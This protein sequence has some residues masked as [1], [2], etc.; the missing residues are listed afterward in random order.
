MTSQYCCPSWQNTQTRLYAAVM[1]DC[2]H[3]EVMNVHSCW[4]GCGPD[5]PSHPQDLLSHPSRPANL[6]Q[7]SAVTGL[8]GD[9]H[10]V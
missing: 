3:L 2:L 8:V 10:P 5:L 7:G 1:E 6:C 4:S 9:E